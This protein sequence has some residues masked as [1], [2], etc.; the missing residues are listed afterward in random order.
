MSKETLAY[1]LHRITTPD[2]SIS[3]DTVAP[4]DEKEFARLLE[5]KAVRTPT[6]DELALY[7]ARNSKRNA[8]KAVAVD[9]PAGSAPSGAAN[10]RR[11]DLVRRAE[12]VGLK[13][14][15][16]I[17]DDKLEEKVIEAEEAAKASGVDLDLD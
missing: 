4:F 8:A 3:P 6:E 13:V 9:K 10:E 11:Q 14:H 12:A 2:G 7:E 1:T 5:K 15:P 17:G 16:N